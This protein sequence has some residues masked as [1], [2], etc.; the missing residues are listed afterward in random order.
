MYKRQA[1]NV[2]ETGL[3][4]AR[5]DFTSAEILLREG[6]YSKVCFLSQQAAEKAIKALLIFK[7]KKFEKIHSVAELVRRVEP[8]KN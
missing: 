1:T 6:R 8:Q 2:G 5:D 7:F 3:D 4:E